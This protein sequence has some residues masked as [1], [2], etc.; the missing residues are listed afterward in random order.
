MP[1]RTKSILILEGKEKSIEAAIRSNG[2]SPANEYFEDL[3]LIEKAQFTRLF[4]RIAK[5]GV[6]L[7]TDKF[8]LLEDGIFEFK[9]PRHRIL[10]FLTEDK[11]LILTNGF[12]KKSQRIPKSCLNL[13]KT[14]REE[15]RGSR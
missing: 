7:N 11:K 14:I 4:E 12:P 8:K 1:Q 13:A 5:H 2:R 6:I 9:T 15:Y 10:C 3:L